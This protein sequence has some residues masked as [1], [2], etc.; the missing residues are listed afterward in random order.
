MD[1]YITSEF[2][3][4]GNINGFTDE[5][6][7][8]YFAS[9]LYEIFIDKIEN[10]ELIDFEYFKLDGVPAFRLEYSATLNRVDMIQIIY[11]YIIESYMYLTWIFTTANDT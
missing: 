11:S 4:F 5:N 9:T 6:F 2:F 1:L 10:P 3:G 8:D 7:E